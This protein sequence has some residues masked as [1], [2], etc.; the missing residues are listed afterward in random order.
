MPLDDDEIARA[1]DAMPHEKPPP[2]L[3]RE[4]MREV[5]EATR[6]PR[7]EHSQFGGRHGRRSTFISAWAAA[8]ALVLGFLLFSKL[9]DLPN[10]T[11]TMAPAATTYYVA[12][13]GSDTNPGTLIAPFRTITKTASVVRPGDIV[14]VRGGVYNEIVKLSAAKGTAAARII[15][16]NYAG[17]NAAIDGAGSAANT[18]LV[19][20]GSAQYIDFTGFEVR[21]STRLGI[22]VFGGKNVR[23]TNNRVHHSFRGGIYVGSPVMGGASDLLVDGNDVYNNVLENQAHTMA[24]GWAQAI[25]VNLADRVTVTNNRV[26]E[27]D[28][29]GIVFVEADNGLA[30]KNTVYDNYSVGIYFDNAQ[31]CTADSNLV[32]STGNTRYYRSGHPAAGIGFANEFYATQNPLT[33]NKVTNNI[34]VNTR[35]GLYYGAYDLGGGLKNT[36]VV[37]NTFYK[38]TAAMISLDAD[39]HAGNV[40]QNNIFFQNGGGVMLLGVATGAAFRSNLWYG[41]NPGAAA[42]AGDI[43]GSNPALVNAGGLS[44]NDYKLTAV[45]PAV[46]TA[47]DS[48]AVTTDFFGGARTPSFDIGAHEQSGPLGSGAAAS[49]GAIDPPSNLRA[50][51]VTSSSIALAWSATNAASFKVYRNGGRIATLSAPAF[52][53][54][55]LTQLTRYT[56]EVS[57]IDASGNET[58]KSV[59]SATTLSADTQKPTPATALASVGVTQTSTNSFSV[60]LAWTAATDNVKVT[61]YKIYRNGSHIGTSPITEYADQG[62]AAATVYQYYVVAIDAAGNS[63]DKSNLVTLSTQ[64][65]K[66]R[67]T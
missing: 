6:V 51:A 50:T 38:S 3:R 14:E 57:A 24:G 40:F 32:Y 39:A 58:L 37:N 22:A 12:T 55:G 53:E 42:G 18:D 23:I 35:W 41:G 64:P 25:G 65:S 26:H 62:L 16:R 34:V 15:Y 7:V 1:L 59:V 31:F 29:E 46:H 8:A 21:N 61:G 67:A 28:G 4:I 10:T 60:T 56:Y 9:R 66:R 2:E 5:S 47:T 30:R 11:G 45:S 44:A 33:G 52:T 48:A 27:N 19:Q 17:E 63:A 20:L 43:L 36:T 13:T 49:A 54:T